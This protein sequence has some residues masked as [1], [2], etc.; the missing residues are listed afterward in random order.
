MPPIAYRGFA[1]AP[2]ALRPL[3]TIL[4]RPPHLSPKTSLLEGGGPPSGGGRSSRA[5]RPY[6]PSPL[7]K[8]L[9]RSSVPRTSLQRPPSSRE[10][11]RPQAVEGVPA[12][13]APLSPLHAPSRS[14]LY[15]PGCRVEP[16]LVSMGVMGFLGDSRGRNSK[17]PPNPLGLAERVLRTPPQ[18]PPSSREG[19]RPQ[20]VEG[21]PRPSPVEKFP[22]STPPGSPVGQSLRPCRRLHIGGF[23]V[24]PITLRPSQRYLLV[25]RTS[26]QRPPSSREGDRP[27]AVEGVPR[28]HSV[29]G[30]PPSH[31]AYSEP[32]SRI[33]L[34]TPSLLRYPSISRITVSGGSGVP[35]S[36]QILTACIR[37]SL[38]L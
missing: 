4:A 33:A 36:A 27:Q 20:A 30:V 18:R 37:N 8:K 26:P 29:E 2:I 10:G 34:S 7:S 14:P 19:D 22:F 25:P 23:A 9:D 3:S 17:S 35:A 11:D 13:R 38:S 24:A 12:H 6:Y 28:P 15:N 1:V 31:P 32:F 21:V 16:L 5:S